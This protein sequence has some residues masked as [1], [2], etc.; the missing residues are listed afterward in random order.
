MTRVVRVPVLAV[1]LFQAS[2][3]AVA[4]DFQQAFEGA[5]RADPT[6]RAA[7]QELLSNEQGVP[8]ARAALLP[9]AALSI[10]DARVTGSR[11]ADNF[12]GQPVT[13]PLAY[14]APQQNL[15]VRLPLFNREASQKYG[16]A[17]VQLQYATAQFA[18]RGYELL[19][20]L[21]QAYL[22][23]QYAEQGVDTASVQL[24][25][26]QEQRRLALRRMELGEGTRPELAQADADLAL[27][28]T[29]LLEARNQSNAAALSVAQISGLPAAPA[30]ALPPRYTA[31][32]L[33]PDQLAAW[34]DKAS[35]DSPTLAARR[36]ALEA[37]RLGVSR[38]GAGHYPR[39]DAVA[40]V[41]RS[42]NES[43]STLNQAVRQRSLGLQFNLP[44]YAGGFV[45]A[46]VTQALAEQEKAQ[47]ELEAEQLD[48]IADVNR[49]FLSV[50]SGIDRVEA[51]QQALVAGELAL[52]AARMSVTRGMGTRADVLRAQSRL[53]DTRR[54]LA[55]AHYDQILARLRLHARAGAPADEIARVIDSLLG[56]Q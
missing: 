9:N 11:T 5:Q 6:Y 27:A 2:L 14:R 8:M 52:D 55:K 21:A 38:A 31:R 44:L 49:L 45:D 12:F 23:R 28:R 19:E 51:L 43:V 29:Q 56:A 50:G 18:V 46:S 17:Q 36:L 20:R 53:A 32:P 35:A 16:L 4:G 39:L 3:A 40:S 25:A 26:A 42:R 48:V 47:A 22:Q 41:S 37:A 54:E 30:G 34:Q 10:S 13:T 33:Q 1:L 7:R 24:A 15:S